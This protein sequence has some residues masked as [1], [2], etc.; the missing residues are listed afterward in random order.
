M[1][2]VIDMSPTVQLHTAYGRVTADVTVNGLR[3]R[4]FDKSSTEM[5]NFAAAEGSLK[6]WLK[7]T[8]SVDFGD[9]LSV[10]QETPDAG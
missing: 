9:F 6:D 8:L 10:Y 2:K 7:K 3:R 5:R 1:P 4:L